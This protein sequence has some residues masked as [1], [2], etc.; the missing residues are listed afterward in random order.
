MD[1]AA[2]HRCAAEAIRTGDPTGAAA[3]LEHALGLDARHPV[4]HYELGRARG[5]AGQLAGA[6]AAYRQAISLRPDFVEAHVSMG[7]ALRRIGQPEAALDAL[8]RATMLRP[9]SFEALINAG[10]ACVDLGRYAEAIAHYRGALA[11]RPDAAIAHRGLARAL[12]RADGLDAAIP[13]YRRAIELAPDMAD[14]W[15]DCGS[16]MFRAGRVQE[17]RE[18]YLRAVALAPDSADAH[19]GCGVALHAMRD[20]ASALAHF[21]RA[22]ARD[23][24]RAGIHANT[25]ATLVELA[26]YG[27][28]E[29]AVD[30][31]L[32]IDPAHVAARF[33]RAMLRLARG[34]WAGGWADYEARPPATIPGAPEVLARDWD[35]R[36]MPHGTLLV[37][38]EQGYGDTLQFARYLPGAAEAAGRLVVRVQQGLEALLT[39]SFPDIEIVGPTARPH[40]DA[41]CRLASLPLLLSR[42]VPWAPTDPYLRIDPARERRRP[43]GSHENDTLTVG[44]AWAGNPAHPRDAIRSLPVAALAPLARV[45]GV[46][47]HAL[48]HGTGAGMAISWPIVDLAGDI[49]DFADTAAA[50]GHLDLIV[51]VDT[52]LAHLAGALGRP[53]WLMLP[54]V[55]DWRWSLEGE[56]TAWY[57]SMRLFRQTVAGDWSAPV[58]QVASALEALARQPRAERRCSEYV[59]A[60]PA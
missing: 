24:V 31:A 27:E 7:I 4:L 34:D 53:V 25:A 8:L 21:E 55:P 12:S 3:L 46:R 10:N 6:V 41:Q 20:Y 28:A 11:G 39:A 32:A 45:P 40:C 5:Q 22:R 33:A 42:I 52:A 59:A 14:A 38:A 26:R 58:A 48:H 51:S 54:R 35:G 23:P 19:E 17:A 18:C 50:V 44:V 43:P 13:H 30:R 36:P 29:A 47:L 16:A 1:I 49:G 56:R 57:P 37:N 15:V 9:G 2:L 60:R